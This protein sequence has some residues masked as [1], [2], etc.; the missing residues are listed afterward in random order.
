MLA[1]AITML[2]KHRALW[3]V[4]AVKA[5]RITSPSCKNK[6]SSQTAAKAGSAH[7]STRP[8]RETN[9]LFCY[10]ATSILLLLPLFILFRFCFDLGHAEAVESVADHHLPRLAA[11]HDLLDLPVDDFPAGEEV[12]EAVVE[13]IVRGVLEGDGPLAH[14]AGFAVVDGSDDGTVGLQLSAQGDAVVPSCAIP[15]AALLRARVHDAA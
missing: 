11:L 3:S 4:T 13:V 5:T 15:G 14:V 6:L 12:H 8:E 1:A 9:K 10:S 2:W 7:P